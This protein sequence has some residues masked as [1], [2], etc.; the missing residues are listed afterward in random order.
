ME[1]FFFH[2]KIFTTEIASWNT[3]LMPF[4]FA[5]HFFLSFLD[6]NSNPFCI[7]YIEQQIG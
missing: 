3:I 1:Q 4:A 7:R 2:L 5:F 6:L